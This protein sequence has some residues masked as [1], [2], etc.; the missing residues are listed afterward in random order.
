MCAVEPPF[1]RATKGKETKIPLDYI[2]LV[3][4]PPPTRKMTIYCST[5]I[6]CV[7]YTTICGGEEATYSTAKREEEAREENDCMQAREPS[8]NV[9]KEP[10]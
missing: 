10:L 4:S 6:H 7:M 8:N 2:Q 1:D 5:N 9:V 3:R